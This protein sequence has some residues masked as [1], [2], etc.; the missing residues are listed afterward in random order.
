MVVQLNLT[1][2]IA[3]ANFFW[4]D[5]TRTK[6]KV[7]REKIFYTG[8][9]SN[10]LDAGPI[11]QRVKKLVDEAMAADPSRVQ[12]PRHLVLFE[13]AKLL[14]KPHPQKPHGPNLY[15]H[16][17]T[18]SAKRTNSKYFAAAAIKGEDIVW[19]QKGS[20]PTLQQEYDQCSE[21]RISPLT[22]SFPTFASKSSIHHQLPQLC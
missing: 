10:E 9:T 7:V 12:P 8:N 2:S 4:T 18:S 20:W 6:H 14:L 3:L 13:M 22:F 1:L 17:E 15:Q 11:P 19:R 21:V 5:H 16:L